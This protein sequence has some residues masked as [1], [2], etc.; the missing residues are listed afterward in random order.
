MKKRTSG[1]IAILLAVLFL[2][3]CGDAGVYKKAASALDA[4]DYSQVI[5]LLD[6]IP[7]YD[8]ADDLREKANAGQLNDIVDNSTSPEC[9]EV[10]SDGSFIKIDTNPLDLDDY[11]N[12]DYSEAVKEISKALGFSDSLWEK[13][14]QTRALDGR[15]SDE[16]EQFS[17]SWSY[18]P[19]SGLNVL[20]ERK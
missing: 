2:S 19:N 6:T 11:Y 4:N 18:H 20:Y 3:G 8:D 9:C 10:A 5:Q 13:M 14:A 16:N 17:V 15:L 12:P 7:E 1:I